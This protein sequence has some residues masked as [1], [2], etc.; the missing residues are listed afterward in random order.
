MKIPA[1][2]VFLLLFSFNIYSQSENMGAGQNLNSL[3]GKVSGLS[4]T[5]TSHVSGAPSSINV[6]GMSSIMLS[7]Q[8]LIIVDG[9]EF[10]SSVSNM[11]SDFWDGIS[12]TSRLNDLDPNTIKKIRVLKG[13]SQTMIYGEKG[14]NGVILITT[15]NGTD[16]AID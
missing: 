8:P 1:L 16:S 14:R 5:N 7:N 15:K 13:L 3:R 10:N 6:R 11:G 12:A 9:V 2:L 4:I